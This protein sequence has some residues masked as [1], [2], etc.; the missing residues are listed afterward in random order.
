YDFNRLRPWDERLRMPQFQF[1][2]GHIK[3]HPDESMDQ[4]K[5]REEAEAR[6]AVMTFILG[7]VAEPVP[8]KY[9]ND[10][11]PDRLAEV[12]GRQVLENE[13]PK[14]ILLRLT[15][16]LRF[17]DTKKETRDIPASSTVEV[18]VNELILHGEMFGG[19]FARLLVP[20]LMAKDRQTY[21]D[22]KNARA[23][24]PPPLERDG[25]KLQ[26]AS[27]FQFL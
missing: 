11:A 9:L 13:D 27:L 12:K 8:S 26:P 16:A 23:A 1:A 25:E 22:P 21:N 4:A 20:Y 14:T 18:P 5:L 15:R 3:P 2:R 6:E 7:L 24:L 10:P 17:T 19:T